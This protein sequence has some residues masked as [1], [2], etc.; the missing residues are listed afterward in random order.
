M[1]VDLEAVS[2]ATCPPARLAADEVMVQPQGPL[3]SALQWDMAGREASGSGA[4]GSL[5]NT[6]QGCVRVPPELSDSEV[7]H[8]LLGDNNQLRAALKQSNA[9]L[10]TRCEEIQGWHQKL[11]EEREFL[12]QR[13]QEARD[14][15]E[16]LARENR[17]LQGQLSLLAAGAQGPDPSEHHEQI[18]SS[19]TGAQLQNSHKAP[20]EGEGDGDDSREMDKRAGPTS[21]P[22]E[23]G[24]EVLRLLRTHKEKLEEGMRE[25]RSRNEELE[26]TI[27][28]GERERE[29]LRNANAQLQSRLSQMQGSGVMQEALQCSDAQVNSPLSLPGPAVVATAASPQLVQL[30]K[31]LQAT[32][33]RYRELQEKLDSLQKTRVQQDKN[34]VLLKQRE[35]ECAQLTKDN[36]TLKAQVTSLLGELHERQ[37]CLEKSEAE[38]ARLEEKLSKTQEALH[39]LDRETEQL[40]TQHSITVDKL[41]LQTQNLEAALKAERLVLTEDKRKLAQLQHAY[42]QLYQDY[43]SKLQSESQAKLRDGE[44]EDLT[45]RL[46]EAERAL[47]LKQDVIDKLKEEVEQQKGTLETV[48]VLTAQAEIYKSD[49]LAER[50]AR[51]KLHQRKEELQEQLNRALAEVD[52]LRLESTSRTR[53]EEM[54]QRHLEDYR[55][56]R[57]LLPPLSG[58]GFPGATIPFSPAQP[59]SFRMPNVSEEL[60]DYRCPKCQYQAPDMDTLQIHVTDCIQ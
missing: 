29:N 49:F 43:D 36:E 51:E 28:E 46:V 3:G 41:R 11:K 25:L 12:G 35:N 56:A 2:T 17:E 37:S 1:R 38:R 15:V 44:V 42:T 39:T 60:P 23:G 14:L 55:A 47:A 20:V 7:I 34:E 57:P 59:P 30:S 19:G 4:Q 21:L 10:R 48:P 18:S 50:E 40:K 33:I 52:R 16:R 58:R 5:G 26:R 53:M 31:Q 13:F 45:S 32:Q 22:M 27:V 9:A 54:Q 24:N 6:S 8:R